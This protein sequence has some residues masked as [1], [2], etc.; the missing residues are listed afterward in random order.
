MNLRKTPH[1][2]ATMEYSCFHPMLQ[3]STPDVV[4]SPNTFRGLFRD[5]T[6]KPRATFSG[7][8]RAKM[9]SSATFR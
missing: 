5:A 9:N 1:Y 3:L 2:T 6:K 7:L 8:N 4:K